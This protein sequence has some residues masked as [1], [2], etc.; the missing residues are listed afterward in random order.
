MSYADDLAQLALT[1]LLLGNWNGIRIRLGALS[2]PQEAQLA[3]VAAGLQGAPEPDAVAEEID[4]LL[5]LLAN[6][7]AADFVR[8]LIRRAQADRDPTTRRLDPT[9]GPGAPPRGDE[10]EG[11]IED[12]MTT[13]RA[14][15]A[16]V[17]TATRPWPVRLYFASNRRPA[18]AGTE[19]FGTERDPERL[20][21]GRMIVTIP[22]GHRQGEI[23]Q[24]PWWHPLHDPRDPD[25]YLV[26][27]A[28]SQWS[29]DEL[30]RHLEV[31]R[32]TA[33]GL[34][35][36]LHGYRVTFEDAARRAAQFA[37]DIA[38]D[39]RVLLFS[40]PSAGRVFSY[41]ADGEQAQLSER[42]LRRLLEALAEGP[43]GPVHLLAHSM[44]NR[45]LLAA[46]AGGDW[47]NRKIAQVLFVAGDVNVGVFEEQFPVIRASGAHYSSYASQRDGALALSA[48]LHAAQRIG[49]IRDEP[50]RTRGL[51]TIDA[52]A[53][54]T[55]L[56]GLGLGH[57]EF[58]ERR[59]LITD[60]GDLIASGLP[61]G[62]RH[63]LVQARTAGLPYWRFPD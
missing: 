18:G 13:A 53:V 21:C 9:A 27:R 48:R 43:W 17:G 15:G 23:E 8:G 19:H 30:L 42:P 22:V 49:M 1:D 63:G 45:V 51:E 28:L 62:K 44:G 3:A 20:S 5:A 56:L 2:P 31:D 25:R 38:F 59:G 29:T 58:A 37:Y 11:L 4:K 47:P 55:S 36:F 16:A 41:D 33:R 6:T 32:R 35:V 60:I 26:I 7:P 10:P 40:W 14:V 12:T 54:N 50:Y 52:T 57:S 34:L 46:L 61:A 39:G 24:R